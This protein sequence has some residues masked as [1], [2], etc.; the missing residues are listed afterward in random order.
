MAG[1]DGAAEYELI[2]KRPGK[3]LGLTDALTNI[4]LLIVAF[5]ILG[6]IGYLAKKRRKKQ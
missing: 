1:V 6:N 3:G 4:H 5:I 2:I